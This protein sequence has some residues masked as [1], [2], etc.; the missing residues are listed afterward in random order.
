M[1]E[2][3]TIFSEAFDFVK[4][5]IMQY[6]NRA[7]PE[8][9]SPVEKALVLGI[10]NLPLP[11]EIVDVE[12]DTQA[13]PHLKNNICQLVRYNTSRIGENKVKYCGKIPATKDAISAV[14][15][16]NFGIPSKE[17]MFMAEDLTENFEYTGFSFD[18]GSHI[19]FTRYDIR[20]NT[21]EFFRDLRFLFYSSLNEHIINKFMVKEEIDFNKLYQLK[22]DP[23]LIPNEFLKPDSRSGHLTLECLQSM[24]SGIQLIPEVPN[25]IKV[26]FQRA[27]DLFIFSYFRYEFATLSDRSALFAFEV[28]MRQ[29]YLQSLKGKAVITCDDQ[30]VREMME[31]S[32]SQLAKFINQTKKSKKSNNV[33]VNGEKFPMNTTELINWLGK[34]GIPKWKLRS[35]DMVRKLRNSLAH[36]EHASIFLPSNGMLL[37]IAYDIN[38]LF[39]SKKE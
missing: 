1:T 26:E 35:Y 13:Y 31:P 39:A 15:I 25:P 5:D 9:M 22:N 28:A 17:S 8:E 7:D 24:V 34:N 29:R 6:N 16:E 33:M 32:Y 27:K 18:D 21:T 37:R 12:V 19:Q 4:K 3:E 10:N 23:I 20:N 2:W 11:V 30:I 36:P 38:E 14:M